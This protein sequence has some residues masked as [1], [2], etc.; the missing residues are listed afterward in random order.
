MKNV[1]TKDVTQALKNKIA[2]NVAKNNQTDA[3]NKKDNDV[4]VNALNTINDLNKKLSFASAQLQSQQQDYLSTTQFFNPSLAKDFYNM[5]GNSLATNSYLAIRQ[6]IG[7]VNNKTP[8]VMQSIPGING[9]GGAG[10]NPNGTAVGLANN[11]NRQMSGWWLWTMILNRITYFGQMFEITCDD[12]E[13][14]NAVYKYLQDVV[15]AGYA[16]IKRDGDKYLN[17][18]CNNVQLDKDGNLK[19]FEAYN[20]AFVINQVNQHWEDENFGIIKNV[21]DDYVWGQWRSNGYNIWY[22]VMCYLMNSVDL[23][24][25]FWNRARLNKTVVLQKKGN[26]S[27][28]SIEAQNFIDPYQNVVTVNTVGVLDNLDDTNERVSI[29]NKYDV[30]DLGHGEET[31]YSFTNFTLWND[32]WDNEIGIRSSP[33]NTNTNRSISD[34]ISPLTIKL[35]KIQNDFKFCLQELCD[36][37]EKQWGKHV[38]I[39]LVDDILLNTLSQQNPAFKAEEG[40][41]SENDKN[42][43]GQ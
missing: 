41:E 11:S 18:C 12:K 34:E 38:E 20:S 6:M 13:L 26:S 7:I 30:I 19:T 28:A 32:Y 29:E 4:L 25:I 3:N 33:I 22:Y 10:S 39:N 8:S 16:V 23:L 35:T 40:N 17:Y 37:I 24:W 9:T 42:N 5:N 15:L 31:Q 43:G 1:D 14:A 21:G 36:R 2:E 27:T